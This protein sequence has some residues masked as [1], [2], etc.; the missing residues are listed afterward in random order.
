[1][2]K[3]TE[4]TYQSIKWALGFRSADNGKICNEGCSVNG[5][6]RLSINGGSRNV[7]VVA[8]IHFEAFVDEIVQGLDFKKRTWRHTDALKANGAW[9]GSEYK[10]VR[11]DLTA[12]RKGVR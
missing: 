8:C 6:A 3:I 11:D 12:S 1:M 4:A 9:D 5:G 2:T 10:I 7:R